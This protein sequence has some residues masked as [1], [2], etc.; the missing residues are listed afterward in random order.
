MKEVYE[1]GR[2]VEWMILGLP[3]GS[4]CLMT[5]YSFS[6]YSVVGAMHKSAIR[7]MIFMTGRK[8]NREV[9]VKFERCVVNC[10]TKEI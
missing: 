2:F 1:I 8:L 3:S 10:T 7:I 5:S 6:R 9:S 4:D